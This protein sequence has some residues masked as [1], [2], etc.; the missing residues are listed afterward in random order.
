[1][2]IVISLLIWI[3]LMALA[4]GGTAAFG[5][6][7]VGRRM[8]SASPE[9]RATL[10]GVMKGISTVSRAALGTLLVTGP[11]IV[12]LK[13]GGFGRLDVWF[14]IKMV[15]VAGLLVSVIASGVM[16]KRAAAG[17]ASAAALGPRLG[18]LNTLLLFGIVLA[19]VFA[20]P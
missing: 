4:A 15:L 13:Y 7:V 8:A 5:M 9:A 20:F 2:D 17:D 18:M 12:W 16:M 11:L 19:A 14:W 3:H 1:M 10:Q 6:P